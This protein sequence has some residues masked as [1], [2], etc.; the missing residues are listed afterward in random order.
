MKGEE[1]PPYECTLITKE[2][3]RI[4]VIETTTLITYEGES[5]IPGG[6]TDITERKRAEEAL[7]ES[8]EKY[9]SLFEN[10]L[11]FWCGV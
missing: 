5:A 1:A 8:E 3:K 2:S 9:R 11:R 6:I 10:M 4:D 7:R